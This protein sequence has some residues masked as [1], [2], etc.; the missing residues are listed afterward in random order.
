MQA[1]VYIAGGVLPLLGG[2]IGEGG[3]GRAWQRHRSTDSAAARVGGQRQRWNLS[4]LEFER[5]S[6][7]ID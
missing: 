7:S 3:D 4:T 1:A 6:I 2:G 5:Y